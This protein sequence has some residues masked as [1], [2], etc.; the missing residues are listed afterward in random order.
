MAEPQAVV[1]HEVLPENL[2]NEGY[3]EFDQL[4]F[5]A[6]FQDRAI[7]LGSIRLEGELEVQYNG[8][9][10]NSITDNGSGTP[11]NELDIKLDPL[12]GAHAFCESWTTAVGAGQQIAENLTEYPRYV[13][14]ASAA[15]SGIDDMNNASHVCELKAPLAAMTNGVLQGVVP[16]TQPTAPIRLNP[17]FSIRPMFAMN[18]GRGAIPYGRTGDVRFTL[19]CARVAAALYGTGVDANVTYKLKDLRITFRSVP[20]AMGESSPVT[21]KTKLNIKQSIQSSFANVQS[22]IPAQV[23]AVSCSFQNQQE[24][25]TYKNNN[26]QLSKVPNLQQTQFLFNDSTNTLVSYLIKT[27][28]EVI[29]R[30][31]DSFMDTGRNTLSTQKLV[32]NDGF[33]LGL[34][35]GQILDL[36]N[37]KFSIQLTSGIESSTPMVI[38]MYF[39]SFVEV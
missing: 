26:L 12:V 21:M 15:T 9:F 30:Y 8:Q 32:N 4:D 22:K 14:M 35:M 29:Q 19:T 16:E 11:I 27:N 20:E 24:E 28:Q 23:M 37:Q 33:G 3:S 5:L 10:L 6:T 38:Y 17:D 34:D 36:S 25:N 39:H 1:Y 7:E 13:K 2:K 31:I 18:S